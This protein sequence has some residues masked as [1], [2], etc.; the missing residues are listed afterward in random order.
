MTLI[1]RAKWRRVIKAQ[2]SLLVFIACPGC[3]RICRLEVLCVTRGGVIPGSME[4]D[5]CGWYDEITL[6]GWDHLYDIRSMM[7]CN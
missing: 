4:C 1:P 7:V 3:R 6:E 5:D 2:H